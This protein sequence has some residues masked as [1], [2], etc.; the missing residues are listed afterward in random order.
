MAEAKKG[1]T[2]RIH[3]TGKLEDGIVFDTSDGR[4][5]LEFTIGEGQVIPGFEEGVLG[6]NSGDSKTVNIPSD[7]AYGPR[8]EELVGEVNR[9]Q[10]PPDVTP[11]IGQQFQ[12]QRP[13][14]QAMEVTVMEV[15]EETVKL[16]ANHPL[17]GKR[18]TFEISLA[19]IV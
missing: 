11:E 17:A 7:Q 5:P 2:V 16:D 14:G 6:M 13:D 10:F 19:E 9:D 15:S 3:Y 8:R 12:M 18:L 4:D 1:D